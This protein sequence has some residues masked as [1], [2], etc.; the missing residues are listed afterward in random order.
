M[1]ICVLCEDKELSPHSRLTT[2]TN[3]RSSM[4]TWERRTTAEVVNRRRRLHIYDMRMENVILHGR[5]V[6]RAAPLIK[7]FVSATALK[8]QAR[9]ER[10]QQPRNGR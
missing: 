4:G 7:P 2:C 3:C 5:D 8:R 10:K 6:R 9:E 1:A